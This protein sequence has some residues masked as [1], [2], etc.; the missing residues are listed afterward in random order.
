[1]MR[2]RTSRD[3]NA[4]CIRADNGLLYYAAVENEE[5][6]LYDAA[7]RTAGPTLCEHIDS[8]Y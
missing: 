1:M 8:E 5:L 2:F 6:G 3:E 4:C 7:L